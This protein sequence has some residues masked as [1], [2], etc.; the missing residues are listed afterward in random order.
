MYREEK[1]KSCLKK[2]YNTSDK[3]IH[4]LC[5]KGLAKQTSHHF[6]STC[7]ICIFKLSYA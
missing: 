7:W 4:C 1:D 6:G 5:N 3:V 2:N